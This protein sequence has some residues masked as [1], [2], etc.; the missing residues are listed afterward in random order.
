[1]SNIFAIS[2][3]F[4]E[5]TIGEIP[6]LQTESYMCSA[7]N[8][9]NEFNSFT[10]ERTKLL[11][12]ALAEAT[13]KAEENQIFEDYFTELTE[14]VGKVINNINE[15]VSRFVMTIDNLADVNADVINN[16]SVLSSCNDFTFS[17]YTYKNINDPAFPRLDPLSHYS[18]EFDAIGRLLQELGAVAPNQAKLKVIATVYNN[19]SS[20]V[21]NDWVEKCMED[22]IGSPLTGD[23]N[24][25]DLLFSKFRDKDPV[26]TTITKGTLYQLKVAMED[27]SKLINMVVETATKLVND[28]EYIMNNFMEIIGGC[29]KNK[30][31]VDTKTDGIRN[32]TYSGDDYTT[33]QLNIFLKSKVDQIVRMC[34]IYYIALSIKL[35]ATV[36]YFDQCKEII[37]TAVMNCD[38]QSAS[39]D[40]EEP[41]NDE[42]VSDDDMTSEPDMDDEEPEEPEG[43]EDN[44]PM[45]NEGEPVSD[46]DDMTTEDEEPEEV[47][48]GLEE[49]HRINDAVRSY[50][51]AVYELTEA[52][53]HASLSEYVMSKYVT[54]A[55]DGEKNESFFK[56]IARKIGELFK[57][58]EEIVSGLI[59]GVDE[60]GKVAK[61]KK[62]ANEI[63][64]NT[65]KSHKNQ[66]GSIVAPKIDF[67]ALD[68]IDIPDM[69][70]DP[71]KMKQL[72]ESKETFMQKELAFSKFKPTKD[73]ET[74]S[75]RIKDVVLDYENGYKD[76]ADMDGVK[77]DYVNFIL[78]DLSKVLASVAKMR[79]RIDKAVDI[80]EKTS[81]SSANESALSK[82]PAAEYF[83]E[84]SVDNSDKEKEDDK[85]SSASSSN[86][87]DKS[88]GS[89][90]DTSVDSAIS[91]YFK[92]CSDVTSAKMS[93]AMTVFNECY[94]F[95]SWHINNINAD[96][97]KDDKEEKNKD[98]K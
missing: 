73:D 11:Y 23:A 19:F 39:S 76:T 83:V 31:V 10:T 60:A 37:N 58:F 57:K 46:D 79:S 4:K 70:T 81:K 52:Y 21:K 92:V 33:N 27:R 38:N 3:V 28:L 17:K 18:K 45:G 62:Y 61:I 41:E 2:N 95:L 63:M 90:K 84:L 32:T 72:Y 86:N 89:K 20:S 26:E 9:L 88:G 13:S 87:N 93:V 80:A 12:D 42:P 91:V 78:N 98:K 22:V 71:D 7:I 59:K 16:T 85:S 69:D 35:D 96:K 75:A 8:A 56:R 30:I 53:T 44:E 15:S 67:N 54:E 97:P 47:S 25:A 14:K 40:S 65:V 94:S 36:E 55:D 51:Y 82:N 50:Q 5:S 48:T 29:G 24:F 74:I 49:C 34:N 68:S 66:D 43:L 6:T 1:M 64:S 77:K